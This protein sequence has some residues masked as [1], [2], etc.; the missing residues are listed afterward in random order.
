M[1]CG[2]LSISSPPMAPRLPRRTKRERGPTVSRYRNA[3]YATVPTRG[4][5]AYRPWRSA[6]P[7]V[8]AEHPPGG[9]PHAASGPRQEPLLHWNIAES[10]RAH[11]SL[12]R[13]PEPCPAA[14][15]RVDGGCRSPGIRIQ[16]PTVG[17]PRCPI[18]ERRSLGRLNPRRPGNWRYPLAVPA[19]A[20]QAVGAWTAVRIIAVE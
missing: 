16:Q 1:T 8:P 14:A 11:L 3:R 12:R 6:P 7:P 2:G 4:V 15:P 17:G 5:F 20:D 9:P 18:T 13:R 10:P 19:V